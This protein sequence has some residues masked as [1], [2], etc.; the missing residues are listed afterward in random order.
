MGTIF[1]TGYPGFL[2]SE[3][4][5]KAMARHPDATATCLVQA[6]FRSL[7]LDRAAAQGREHPELEGRIRIVEGDITL[8][9]LGLGEAKDLKPE[10]LEL[11]HLAALYDLSVE[12][13]KAMRV[14]VEGTLHVLDFAAGCRNLRRF[15]YVSTCYVSGRYVGAFSENE[16][17]K[18]Q[19]FNNYYEESKHIAEIEVR[20]RMKDG[21]PATIYRPSIVVGD[22]TT[23]A[24][25]KFDGPYFI[26]QL[27]L[28]QPK[29]AAVP[30]LGDPDRTRVNVVPRDFVLDAIAHLAG[31]E[32]SLGRTY[33]LC[34]PD[35][36]TVKEIV[37]AMGR[38]CERVIVPIPL[39]HRVARF[40]LRSIPLLERFLGI[41]AEATDYFV[42]PTFYTCANTLSDLAGT[43]IRC[44][45]L[46]D[47]LPRLVTF[48]RQHPE[49]GH[50][51]MA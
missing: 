4:L 49:I 15:H 43:G 11:W 12:R 14:N 47:Y 45:P 51:A 40:S 19:S 29:V 36:L 23:G 27:I 35:P 25:Q 48:L 33:A 10:V 16:L 26:L 21:L 34:D 31:Q 17:E 9:D 30:M 7:A 1:F 20:R 2:G 6:K 18:G 5:P 8:P 37:E 39:M 3:L 42:H 41:P 50:R 22:S 24:T 38:A 13:E 44:P 46:P 28:R 32:K